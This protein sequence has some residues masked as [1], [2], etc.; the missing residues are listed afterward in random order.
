MSLVAPLLVIR[1][2]TTKAP[3][4]RHAVI[5][6]SVYSDYAAVSL[7][8]LGKLTVAIIGSPK[9]SLTETMR[10]VCL[11]IR[12]GTSK[13]IT[14]AQNSLFPGYGSFAIRKDPSPSLAKSR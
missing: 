10:E 9:W 14:A 2:A 11:S 6:T 12:K 7:S 13:L 5:S 1:R 8:V 3:A 4:D